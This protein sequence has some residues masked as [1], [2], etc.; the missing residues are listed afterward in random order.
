[1]LQ[2]RF[3]WTRS[4]ALIAVAAFMWQFGFGMY[5]AIYSNFL[6]EELGIHAQQL[7]FIESVREFPGLITMLMAAVTA[8]VTQSVLAGFCILLVSVG[9]VLYSFAGGFTDLIWMTLIFSTGFHLLYPVQNA[10]VLAHAKEGEKGTRMGQFASLA[11]I[12]YL[13][14]M[15]LV[16]VTSQFTAF[17]TYFLIA[18]G[19]TALGA[20]AMFKVPRPKERQQIRRRI[21]LNRDYS[22]YYFLTLL[23]GSRR[24]IFL[25]FGVYNLVQRFGVPVGTIA[26]LLAIGNLLSVYGRPLMGKFVDSVGERRVLTVSY[27]VVI[28]VFAGYAFISWVPALYVLFCIDALF[29]FEFVLNTYLDKIAEP[30]DMAPTLATGST[31][32]HIAGVLVPITGGFLWEQFSPVATFI[33]GTIVAASGLVYIMIM[34]DERIGPRFGATVET[35]AA[36]GD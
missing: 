15:G 34:K 25:T 1:M 33:A 10:L 31:I 32:N 18:A 4:V 26:I 35:P 17:R 19:V 20:V 3:N 22:S 11:A 2:K 12:G 16:S 23:G 14:A 8:A 5:R 9:L 30:A 27:A 28:L 36:G 13:V 24:H 21:V 7:G 29:R 6:W